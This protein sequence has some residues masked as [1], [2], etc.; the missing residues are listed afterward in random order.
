MAAASTSLVTLCE[1][2]HEKLKPYIIR[3]SLN[4]W[5]LDQNTPLVSFLPI[6]ALFFI[7]TIRKIVK[8]HYTS[9]K[10]PQNKG[11]MNV[12][13]RTILHSLPSRIL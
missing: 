10:N 1:S 13:N 2:F 7:L 6:T 12:V 11:D 5:I 9:L 4:Q 8:H 3:Y